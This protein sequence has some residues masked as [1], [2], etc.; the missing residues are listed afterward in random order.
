MFSYVSCRI[1]IS[2]LFFGFQLSSLKTVDQGMQFFPS[3]VWMFSPAPV[4]R[5]TGGDTEGELRDGRS[6]TSSN[7]L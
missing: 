2:M 5:R 7:L 6:A 3:L 4:P 1:L